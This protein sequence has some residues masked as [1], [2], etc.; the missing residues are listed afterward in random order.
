MDYPF[1]YLLFSYFLPI[2][3]LV[4]LTYIF[5]LKI[6]TCIYKVHV[7]PALINEVQ[8]CIPS[9]VMQLRYVMEY[10]ILCIEWILLVTNPD[11]AKHFLESQCPNNCCYGDSSGCQL[12]HGELQLLYTILLCHVRHVENGPVPNEYCL[13]CNVTVWFTSSQ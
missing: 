3:L 11:L 2:I 13:L 9:S 1:F 12:C 10:H 8:H 4:S 7:S 5:F 6:L